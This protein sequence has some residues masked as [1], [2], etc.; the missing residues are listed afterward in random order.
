MKENLK[1]QFNQLTNE[2]RKALQQTDEEAARLKS[3]N[4]SNVQ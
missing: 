1:T 2:V 3:Q 4:I